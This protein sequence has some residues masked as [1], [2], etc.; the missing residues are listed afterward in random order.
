VARKHQRPKIL[1]IDLDREVEAKLLNHGYNV[2]SGSFGIPYEVK[3]GAG[4]EPVVID[5]QLPN[6]SEQEIII[7]DLFG[8][9]P[10][11]SPRVEKEVPEEEADWWA[12]CS[13]GRID[14]RPRVMDIVREKSDRILR[15]GGV[16]IIFSDTPDTQEFAIGRRPAGHY[17][18][19][20]DRKF[21]LNNWGFLSVLRHLT[22]TADHGEEIEVTA[23][24][25]SL[26]RIL[27]KHLDGASF[28]CTLS[29]SFDI[30]PL[31]QELA[32]NKFG[33]A[34]AGC[35][36]SPKDETGGIFVLPDISD[37]GSLLFDL[38]K[39]VLP[40]LFPKLFPDA[41]G[42]LWVHRP[43]YEMSSV[44]AKRQTIETIKTEAEQR[45]AIL[46]E[47]ILEQQHSN[48][49]L[50]DLLRQTGGKL[51][52]AVKIALGLIGFKDVVDV[53]EELKSSGKD[54]SLREDLRIHDNSPVLVVDVKGVAGKPA[55]HEALQ[56]QKHAF[57]YIQEQNRADVR[58]LSII[59]H[60][61]LLPPLDRENA[62]PFRQ[63]ILDNAAQVK[64][65]LLTAFDLFRLVRGFQ[66]NGWPQEEV[67]PILYQTG[68]ITPVP[69]HYNYLGRIV[70]VW[71]TA[72][73][74]QIEA[75]E[76]RIGDR[77]AVEFPVDF[78]EQV[79]S[80]LRLNDADAEIVA[81]GNEAGI[82]RS[83]SSNA[84]IRKGL[85]VYRVNL[86]H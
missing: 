62:M 43:E 58:G 47:S 82:A 65:G 18:I 12:K 66:R 15:S 77:I 40:E 74:V 86:K 64:L 61:R 63:E 71:K 22:L 75:N 36:I 25:S 10:V 9:E 68:R 23:K 83:P 29:P 84:K 44:I 45:I 85:S 52:D 59:N 39:D 51:V 81:V 41:E 17:G 11:P 60:Q 4:Y 80:S 21:S 6:Y 78:E 8:R 79:V 5:A 13:N 57:I 72:F 3:K 70:Q 67:T 76:L 2:A 30:R 38:L 55:D 1:L 33:S 27:S 53:D 50:Y 31:W 35:I 37:K 73:S 56:A 42:Q 54:R 20:A 49:F 19:V 34:V 32:A 48:Q 7:I 14:P 69:H 28:S 26:S 24:D 16:F 46:E